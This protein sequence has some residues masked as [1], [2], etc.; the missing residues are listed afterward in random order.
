MCTCRSRPAD[1]TTWTGHNLEIGAAVADGI[2]DALHEIMLS[3]ELIRHL[4][5]LVAQVVHV[6]L[7]NVQLVLRGGRKVTLELRHTGDRRQ[8]GCTGDGVR[9][10]GFDAL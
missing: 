1:E 7:N 3:S 8:L 2:H 5:H 4:V 6:V 9:G 10:D